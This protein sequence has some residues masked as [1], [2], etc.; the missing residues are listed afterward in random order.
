M[1]TSVYLFTIKKKLP[2]SE[3]FFDLN[4]TIIQH[5]DQASHRQL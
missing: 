4:F 2:L 5:L 3:S 1:F